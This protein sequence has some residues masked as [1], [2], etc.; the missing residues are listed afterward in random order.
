MLQSFITRPILAAVIAILIALVGVLS[1]MVLPISQYPDVVPPTIQLTAYYP[2]AN[3]EDVQKT[4]AVP[5]EEQINGVDG[6]TYM[7]SQCANDGSCNITVYFAVGTDADMATVN[8]QNRAQRAMN[9]LPAEV[10][11]GGVIVQKKSPS[12]LLLYSLISTDTAYDTKFLANYLQINIVSVLKRIPGVGDVSMFGGDDY[13]M[14]I[15]LNPERMAGLG[16]TAQDVQSAIKEQNLQAAAGQ[17]GKSP[18]ADGQELSI[19]LRVQGRLVDEGQFSN[20]IIK[21]NSDG[22]M[23]RMKDIA[24]IEM[25]MKSYDALG[26]FN[27]KAAP[28]ISIYQSPGSNAVNVREQCDATMKELAKEFPTGITYK[29]GLDTVEFVEAS[30]EEVLMTL[31]EAFVLVFIVVFIFLQDWRATLIPAI[32]VPISL[33][34]ALATFAMFGFSINLLTLFALVLAIGIVVDDAIVVLEAVQEKIDAEGL[35]PLEAT[36]HTMKD[37]TGAIMTITLVLCAVFIPVAFLG[38]T[39]GVMYKQFALTLISSILISALLALTLSPPLCV[40]LLKP[41]KEKTGLIGKFFRGFDRGFD[42]TTHHYIRIVESFTHHISRPVMF[43]GIITILML[44]VMKFLPSGF[45]PSEDQ[46]YF[47]VNVSCPKAYSLQKTDEV[48]KQ[49][50]QILSKEEAVESYTTIPGFSILDNS[51]STTNGMAFVKLKPWKERKADSLHVTAVISKIQAK[52]NRLPGGICM[53]FNAP[54]ISGLG[55]TG[56]LEMQ[57]EDKTGAGLTKMAGVAGA[58]YTEASKRKEI[59]SSFTSFRNDVPQFILNV[60]KEKAK[61]MGVPINSIYTSLQSLFGS[62]YV[63][64]FNKFGKSYRVIIQADAIYRANKEDISKVY[65][66]SNTNQMV[67]LGTLVSIESTQGPDVV[68]R[69]N[70]YS[71]A[72]FTISPAPGYS[73]GQAIEAV[74]EVAAKSL[75]F[76]FGYEYS[77]MTKEELTS[78]GQAPFIFALCFIFVYFLLAAKYESWLMPIPILLALPFGIF[79]AFGLQWARGLQ[80]NIYAQI[81]LIMLIGLIAKNAILIVEFAKQKYD[82]GVPLFEAARDGAKLRFRPILMTSFAF[83]LGVVPLVTATGAGSASRNALGTSVFGGMLLATICGVLVVPSLY[84]LFQKIEDKLKKK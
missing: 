14:R 30:I 54:A 47:F 11:Q 53:A 51:V 37:I 62:V 13:A 35:S 77:G 46:G 3:A 23:V 15:W 31:V 17:L 18:A 32:T 8:V 6:M 5:L 34:G 58:F 24:R 7:T 75:P 83:I 82:S 29:K 40:M 67:P 74:K 42:K 49:I 81:G 39:T 36:K 64:D 2:G 48:M 52:F 10:I 84:V 25:G 63:N 60:D 19:M 73:T 78:G 79:G 12:I 50:E 69:F 57:L 76:G 45:I 26:R 56:G 59:A 43:L 16:V 4:V 21:A 38:G 1:M 80:N 72:D 27:G 65:V 70:L 71:S 28:A 41:K 66:R 55:K 20:I 9:V 44:V 22:S 68:K 61:K 33:V